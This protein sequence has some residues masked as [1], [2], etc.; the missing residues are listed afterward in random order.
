L[1]PGEGVVSHVYVLPSGAYLLLSKDEHDAVTGAVG[2]AG[3][4]SQFSVPEMTPSPHTFAT[5]TSTYAV[6]VTVPPG[7]VHSIPYV[8]FAVR[9]ELVH[10]PVGCA[11]VFPLMIHSSGPLTAVQEVTDPVVSH[12]RAVASFIATAEGVAEIV[13]VGAPGSATATFEKSSH[14]ATFDPHAYPLNLFVARSSM[15]AYEPF[16]DGY[17]SIASPEKLIHPSHHGP[18]DG[19]MTKKSFVPAAR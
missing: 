4:T 15:T 7:P 19:S 6:S 1:D 17:V 14:P 12:E 8:G 13:T 11:S 3:E 9:G 18:T 10:D 5:I 2:E 16:V